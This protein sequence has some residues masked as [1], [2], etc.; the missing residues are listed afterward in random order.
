MNDTGRTFTY[1]DPAILTSTPRGRR[2]RRRSAV[3]D[4]SVEIKQVGMKSPDTFSD[5]ELRNRF[6]SAVTASLSHTLTIHEMA[7]LPLSG[8]KRRRTGVFLNLL[9]LLR[10]SGRHTAR[11]KN[12]TMLD[13]EL[14]PLFSCQ[15]R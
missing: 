15:M 6:H 8:R 5:P 12:A 4:V 2:R 11:H 1:S 10:V 3:P 9:P 7:C 13:G 14:K